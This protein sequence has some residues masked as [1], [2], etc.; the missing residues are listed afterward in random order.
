MFG[1]ADLP[2]GTAEP[3]PPG[4]TREIVIAW[5]MALACAACGGSQDSSGDTGLGNGKPT[6]CAPGKVEACACPGGGQGAQACAEDGASWGK[7]ECAAGEVDAGADSASAQV[8]AADAGVS[9]DESG[10]ERMPGLDSRCEDAFKLRLYAYI[11]CLA[12]PPRCAPLPQG[13]STDACCAVEY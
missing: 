6:V 11:G 13:L 5:A 12:L 7:C 10:C 3:Y 1:G 2:G 4:M 8:D 9:F